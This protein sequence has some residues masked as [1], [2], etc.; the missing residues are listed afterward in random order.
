M[1]QTKH[2]LIGAAGVIIAAMIPLFFSPSGQ[3]CDR[4]QQVLSPTVLGH[5]EIED[6]DDGLLR[7]K[8]LAITRQAHR[9]DAIVTDRSDGGGPAIEFNNLAKSSEETFVA[10]GNRYVLDVQEMTNEDGK[11]KEATIEIHK[12]GDCSQ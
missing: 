8:L 6:F 10:A 7:I 11:L 4:G 3:P 12:L 5:G 1:M 2:A 9:F